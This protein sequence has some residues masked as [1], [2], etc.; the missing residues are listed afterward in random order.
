MRVKFKL[1]NGTRE[2]RVPHNMKIFYKIVFYVNDCGIKYNF[3][4]GSSFSSL[5]VNRNILDS[6]RWKWKKTIF[7]FN[8]NNAYCYNTRKPL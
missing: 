5:F 8:D 4:L 7:I 6:E 1:F 2:T 3:L